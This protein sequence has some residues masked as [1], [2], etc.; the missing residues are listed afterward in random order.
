MVF[1][2]GSIPRPLQKLSK[3]QS[4]FDNLEQQNGSLLLMPSSVGDIALEILISQITGTKSCGF[5]VRPLL[6]TMAFQC[7]PLC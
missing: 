6:E 5:R 1:E 7:L 3:S 2:Y 4:H